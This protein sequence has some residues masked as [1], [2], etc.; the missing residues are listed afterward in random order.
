MLII[1]CMNWLLI[2]SDPQVKSGVPTL[3]ETILLKHKIT[4]YVYDADKNTKAFDS[5]ELYKRFSEA[6]HVII[7]DEKFTADDSRPPEQNNRHNNLLGYLIGRN[8]PVFTVTRFSCGPWIKQVCF[9][10]TEEEMASRLNE[11][12]DILLNEEI[13]VNS[14][15]EL[16]YKGI[17]FTANIFATYIAKNKPDICSLFL[18]AGMSVNVRDDEGTPMLNIAA[19]NDQIDLVKWLLK[20]GADVNAI[21]KDRGYSATMDA[22]WKRNKDVAA[23]LISAGAD[24]SVVSKEGQS[25]L[26][27]AVGIGNTEMC[28]MLADNGADPDIKDTMGM[29]AYEYAQLFKKDD[30]VEVL[31]KYHKE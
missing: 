4:P 1:I 14:L 18:H 15:S 5:E 31:K 30:I 8:I 22:V 26:V 24:L 9:F 3:S 25:I 20:N 19:R 13:R 10:D 11:N 6:T 21:S 16:M 7:S 17:P 27:L 28:K 2:K 29:S 12:F 23:L